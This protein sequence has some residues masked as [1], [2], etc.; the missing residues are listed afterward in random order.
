MKSLKYVIFIGIYISLVFV[1]QVV[2]LCECNPIIKTVYLVALLS[3]GFLITLKWMKKKEI[4]VIC[5][6]LMFYVCYDF[7]VIISNNFDDLSFKYHHCSCEST[8][9]TLNH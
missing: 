9:G 1:H 4:K 5:T 3:I 7:L 8:I 6:I 2:A